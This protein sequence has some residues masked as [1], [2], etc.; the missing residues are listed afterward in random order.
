[1][2]HWV[3][4]LERR[5]FR[6]FPIMC[7]RLWIPLY[8]SLVHLFNSN[9][10]GLLKISE[11]SQTYAI[12]ITWNHLMQIAYVVEYMQNNDTKRVESASA[13][14][15]SIFWRVTKCGVW[16]SSDLGSTK[17]YRL[18]RKTNVCEGDM[19]QLEISTYIDSSR[20]P[21][22]LRRQVQMMW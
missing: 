14:I 13:Y 19:M 2:N 11:S 17:S 18:A 15:E 4:L 12:A 22:Q 3:N 1:M 9:E 20:I 16:F 8:I 10:F 7:S 21:T 6:W 5:E